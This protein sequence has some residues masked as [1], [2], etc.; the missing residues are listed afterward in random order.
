M[1]KS[2]LQVK[3]QRLGSIT[4]HE[5]AFLCGSLDAV[6]MFYNNELCKHKIWE[7][8]GE[9]FVGYRVGSDR[10]W[11]SIYEFRYLTPRLDGG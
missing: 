1:V 7:N 5:L 2:S 9:S 11:S 4:P 10:G 3:E 6:S 8:S